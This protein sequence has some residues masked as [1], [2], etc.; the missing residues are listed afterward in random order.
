MTVSEL[1]VAESTVGCAIGDGFKKIATVLR[2]AFGTQP[3]AV[4]QW[5]QEL[6]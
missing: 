6:K 4:A 5:R 2:V 3:F 1:T